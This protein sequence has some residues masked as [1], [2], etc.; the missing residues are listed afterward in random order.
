[1]FVDSVNQLGV[2]TVSPTAPVNPFTGDLWFDKTTN[3]LATWDGT[4][5]VLVTGTGAVPGGG[6]NVVIS[7]IA[8][9]APKKDDIWIDSSNN[10]IMKVW[11]G[12]V[13]SRLIDHD[14]G[15]Y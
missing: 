8:P 15:R 14:G 4:A 3:G 9:A 10:N 12:S 7:A 5:W 2:V 13:F 11:D 6:A 1:M